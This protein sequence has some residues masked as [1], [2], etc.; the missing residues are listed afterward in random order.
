V[1]ELDDLVFRVRALGQGHPFSSRA[2]RY[3]N[4]V[5]A[6]ERTGQP[7]PEIG[8]WAGYAINAGYCLRRVEEDEVGAAITE[9]PMPLPEG[10]DEAA[11]E[12]AARIR[13]EGADP[14]LLYGEERVVDA[15]D[16]LIG[17]EI[18]RR[19]GHW[20]ETIDERS[21]EELED[22]LAWWVVKGYALRVVEQLVPEG[23]DDIG[24]VQEK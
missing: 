12:V 23:A 15:L 5:V 9:A 20:A 4:A 22:Y 6:R 8:I 16:R 10:L 19:L 24:S 14:F 3:V 7:V 21:W 17:G 11:T 18:E 1:L 2:Y 13:T